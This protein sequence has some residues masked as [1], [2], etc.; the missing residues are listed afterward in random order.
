VSEHGEI[1]ATLLAGETSRA[2]HLMVHHLESITIRALLP[3][4]ENGDIRDVLASYAIA[5]GLG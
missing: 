3:K 2:V 1:L 4:E 5:E